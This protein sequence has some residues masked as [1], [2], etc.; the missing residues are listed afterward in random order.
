MEEYDY[1]IIGSGFG[2]SVSALRLSEKGYSVLV[3]EKGKWF[4]KDDFPKSNWHLR[5]WL[6]LPSMRFYG[7]MKMTFY[8][9]IG[10]LSGTGVGGGSL[11]Y[12]NTLPRPKDSFYKTGSWANL[13]DWEKELKPHYG[14]AYKM[15]GATINPKLEEGDLIL[16]ELAENHSL[17]HKFNPTEVA[18]FFGEPEIEV[19]DPF[20]NGL[21]PKRSG[22]TFCGGCMTGCQFDAKN[23]LDKNYLYLAQQKGCKIIAEQEVYNIIPQGEKGGEG[24]IIQAREST[25][26]IKHKKSYRAKNVIFAGGVLGTMNLLLKLKKTTLP[27]LSHWL[28]KNIL[29]N[30]EALIF[31]I[32]PDKNYN[33]NKGIAIGSIL[34]VDENTSLEVV[35]YNENSGFWRVG[36]LP[37]VKAGNLIMRLLRM[38]WKYLSHPGRYFRIATVRKFGKQ[39]AVLLFMQQINTKLT[40]EKGL[41][42]LKSKIGSGEKPQ[43]Q[44]PLAYQLAEDYSR[45]TGGTPMVF[46]SETLLNIPSTAHILGGAIM[47]EDITKGVIDKNHR[48]FG[49]EN[50]MICDGSTLSANPGVNPSLTITAMTERAMESIPNKKQ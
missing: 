6:W 49:Y 16:K 35:R 20:F 22:C 46:L 24:Y 27:N 40:F 15:L 32:T 1:I 41:F 28:G 17:H 19:D 33:L 4:G 30:N 29:T 50:M 26:I 2:G 48:V 18:V 13:S 9:H 43:A 5:K 14:T 44:I 11:V 31:S 25:K 21:G 3:I 36:M 7:I 23:S 12:A 8:K 47:G 37:N 45:I 39:S 34:D 38:T 10:I 42:R